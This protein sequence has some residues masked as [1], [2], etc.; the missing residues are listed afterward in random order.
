MD[1]RLRQPLLRARGRLHPPPGPVAAA[2]GASGGPTSTA[3]VGCWSA[4]RSTRTS[5][6]PR[7]TRWPSPGPCY[8]WYRGN[9]RRQGIREAF[10]ELEPLRPE[11][12]DRELRLKVMDEQGLAGTLL[13]PTLGVGIEDALKHDPEACAKVFQAFNR[14]LDED[15]GYRYEGRIFAVPYIPFLDPI[16]AAAELRRVLDAGAVA[17][18]VRNAPVPVPGGYRSPFDPAYDA[19]LGAG[20]RGGDR[21]GDPRRHRGLRRPR[22]DVGAGRCRELAVPLAAAGH[23]HQGPGG[24][25]LLRRR[26]VP[27][28]LRAFPEPAPGQRRERRRR[29][30]PT[31]STASTTPPTATPATSPS[32][33]AR[34]SASTCGSRRSGRTT[35]PASWATCGST[36][37]SSAPTGRTPRAPAGPWTS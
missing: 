22:A 1:L 19:L 30:C 7:S 28:G 4:A 21:R 26:A 20:R 8:D 34:S 3:A 27:Q 33:H 13:F 36:G 31:S 12:R 16:A 11:Y 14:W 5:P 35:S 18:N 24:Q 17:V 25:R 9:P 10:G 23:R 37:S 32:T 15:W 2:T 6:T 29:G